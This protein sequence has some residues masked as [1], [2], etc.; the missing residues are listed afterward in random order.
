MG[1]PF[2]YI[3]VVYTFD[4]PMNKILVQAQIQ[5]LFKRKD[6]PKKGGGDVISFGKAACLFVL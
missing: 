6:P 3:E 2:K 4:I 1:K 5:K